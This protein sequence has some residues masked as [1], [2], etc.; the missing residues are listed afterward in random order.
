MPKTHPRQLFVGGHWVRATGS[1]SKELVNPADG[2][3][4]ADVPIA[5]A[6][7]IDLAIASAANAF[8]HGPWPRTHP[9]ERAALMTTFAEALERRLPLFRGFGPHRSAPPSL[10]QVGWHRSL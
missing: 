1:K 9:S 5:T 4:L 7:E 3:T 8:E 6:D 2:K 10:W